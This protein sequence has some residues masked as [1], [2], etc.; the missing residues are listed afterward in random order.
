MESLNPWKHI[1]LNLSLITLGL[2]GLVPGPSRF[3]ASTHS[4]YT[5]DGEAWPYGVVGDS[6]GSG[7][8]SASPTVTCYHAADPQNTCAAIAD[9]QGWCD[10][11]DDKKYINQPTGE[12]CAWTTL[13]ATTLFDCGAPPTLTPRV[14]LD[15]PDRCGPSG[16]VC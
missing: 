4:L 7:A 3:K 9:S 5:R 6:W 11:G 10:C 13:P 14:D 2:A 15:R 1:F 8:Q 12:P 16:G